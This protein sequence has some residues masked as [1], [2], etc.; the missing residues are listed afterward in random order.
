MMILFGSESIT[1]AAALTAGAGAVVSNLSFVENTD[2]ADIIGLTR[3]AAEVPAYLCA[4]QVFKIAIVGSD[5]PDS[6]FVIDTVTAGGDHG[7][8]FPERIAARNLLT[9]QQ[10]RVRSAHIFVAQAVSEAIKEGPSD[11]LTGFE[12]DG[13]DE[14]IVGLDE[15]ILLE[16][17][18]CPEVHIPLEDP[19]VF[20][21]VGVGLDI[22]DE[23]G[24][25]VVAHDGRRC[26][27]GWRGRGAARGVVASEFALGQ[28]DPFGSRGRAGVGARERR[29]AEG[30]GRDQPDVV[31]EVGTVGLRDDLDQWTSGVTSADIRDAVNA[32]F[33]A[34]AHLLGDARATASSLQSSFL[35]DIGEGR[36]KDVVAKRS[37][38]HGLEL[39]ADNGEV[40]LA[41]I[42]YH[43]KNIILGDVDRFVE[44]ANG[45]IVDQTAAIVVIGMTDP[46][47]AG[48]LHRARLRG[49]VAVCAY[50][51]R[52][53]LVVS[54]VSRRED[55]VGSYQGSTTSGEIH[56][57]GVFKRRSSSPSVDEAFGTIR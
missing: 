53:A 30:S 1:C 50:P 26:F 41:L 37:E 22:D 7:H 6:V 17:H 21:G 51:Q 18:I 10:D 40:I 46:L 44:D 12:A 16:L 47:G 49:P 8:K 20:R 11:C 48:A 52:A 42:V 28:P 14:Q 25:F 31:V 23:G 2:A 43:E 57:I 32:T 38:S 45:P 19:V 35:D 24:L 15:R 34:G 13:V 39:L 36:E 56:E 3:V 5:D 29:G 33:P 27:G 55:G 9:V 54:A 4:V